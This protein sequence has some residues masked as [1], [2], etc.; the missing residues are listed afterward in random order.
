[1]KS[2]DNKLKKE[3]ISRGL[4][5]ESHLQK[6]NDEILKTK[7]SVRQAVLKLGFL[8]EQD[9]LTVEADILSVSFLDLDKYLFI[10]EAIVK[11]VPESVARAHHVMPVFKIGKLTVATSDASDILALDEVRD[12]VG[13]DIDIVLSTREMIERAIEQY[14]GGV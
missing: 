12:A 3:L 2:H 7:C 9:V 8:T 1:M 5:K 6:V 4:L 11:M 14:Y 13:E 10:N